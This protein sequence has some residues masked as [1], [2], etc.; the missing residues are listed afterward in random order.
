[1]LYKDWRYEAKNKWIPH[2]AII[3]RKVGYQ[4]EMAWLQWIE[5]R[6]DCWG[7]SFTDYSEQ[8]SYRLKE[9]SPE[10]GYQ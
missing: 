7:G 4:G 3:P 9:G 5:K 6:L 8:W 2:F 1:M 10:V